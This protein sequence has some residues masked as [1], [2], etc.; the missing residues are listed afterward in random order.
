MRKIYLLLCV[1]AIT[2]LSATTSFSQITVTATA[3]V[4][5]PTVYT[6][7]F[8]AVSAV[9]AGTH[10]G[11][12]NMSVTANTVETSASTLNYSG[13]GLASYTSITIKPAAATSPTIQGTL[14]THILFIKGSNV[15]ID[16]SNTAGGTS[17]DL[18]IRN[19]SAASDAVIRFGSP[20][21]AFGASNNT[22][23]NCVLVNSSTG[24]CGGV[25]LSGS[26]TTAYAIG[27]APNSNNTIQNNS[28][29]G[30]Q[31]GFYSYGPAPALDNGWTIKDNTFNGLG[32]SGITVYNAGNLRISGN[33]I[34]NVS[35]NGGTEVTGICLSWT[36]SGANIYNNNIRGISN[37]YALASPAAMGIYFDLLG[38]ASN[39]NVYNNFVSD[40]IGVGNATFANN[41][42][43]IYV[44]YGGGYNI[45][46]N[47]VNLNTDQSSAAGITAALGFNPAA[48]GAIPAGSVNLK[49]NILMNT[50]TVGA[51]YSIYST[52]PNTIF[53]SIDYNDY[54]STPDL[55]FIGGIR[56]TLANIQAGFGSNLSSI[57]FA[58]TLMSGTDLHLFQS[59]LNAALAVG[60]PITIPL[61][62]TDIDG[63]S[64]SATAPT[65]GADELSGS[66]AY[67]ALANT[68]SATDVT[69]N[70]VTI[71]SSIGV[72]ISGALV[73]RIYFKKGAGTWYSAPGSL[74]SGTATAGTWSFVIS[75]TALGGVTG[76]DVISYYVIAQT[77]SGAIFAKPAMG[78]VASDVNTV[79]TP[80]TTPN[81]YTVQAVSLAGL[82]TTQS[83]CYNGSAASSATFAYTGSAGSPNQYM[84]TWSP[85][86]PTDVAAF[87]ALPVS[88]LTV[89]VPAGTATDIYTGVLTIFNSTTAC[90]NTYTLTLTVNPQPAPIT[91]TAITCVG[92]TTTLS[93]ATSGGGWT[94]TPT[95]TATVGATNGVVM[96]VATGTA[97]VTYT[98]PTGCYI[99]AVFTVS[100]PPAAIAGTGVVCVGATTTLTNSVPGGTWTSANPTYASA[101]TA[102]GVITGGAAGTATISYN[103]SSCPAV[104]TVVTVNPVPAAITGQLGVCQS[105]STTLSDATPGGTWSSSALAVATIGTSGVVHGLTPGTSTITYQLTSTG[106]YRTAMVTVFAVPGPI[107]GADA[108]CIG[109]PSSLFNTATTGTWVSGTPAVATIGLSSGVVT[110][111]MNGTTTI[112]YTLGGSCTVTKVVS[113]STA[114]SV[115]A[116]PSIVCTGKT[117]TL[118][119][120]TAGG[121]WSS[122]PVAIGTVSSTGIVTGVTPGTVTISDSTPGCAMAT[123]VVTVNL[124]PAN[125][126]GITNLCAGSTTTLSNAT[127]GGTWSSSNSAVPVTSSGIVSGVSVGV[128]AVISYTLPNGCFS[129]APIVADT[130]PAPIAGPDSVCKFSS[131]TLTDATPAGLWTSSDGTKAS[132]VAATGVV[133][134]LLSGTVTISYTRVSGCYVTKTFKVREPL[135]ASVT[136]E[137]I[138]NTIVCDGT[139][140]MFIAHPVNGGVDP[141]FRWQ[142]FTIDTAVGDTFTY[143]PHH[144]DFISLYMTPD[145]ICS[146]PDPS[147]SSVYINVYPN[148]V[149]PTVNITTTKV[150]NII[151]F[152]GEIVTF[153]SDITFGGTAPT[154][155][156]YVND[157][158]VPGA[159]NSS[160]TLEVYRSIV[161]YCRVTGN[162]PCSA[163][164]SGLSNTIIIYGLDGINSVTVGSAEFGLF[165]NP[166]TGAFTLNGTITNGT[167]EELAIEVTNMLGQVVYQGKA[168]PHNGAVSQQIVLGSDLAA[169]SYLMRVNSG[170]VNQTFH[171]VISK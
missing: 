123:K 28:L 160:Y 23:K 29:T 146:A 66:I 156:W 145:S 140:M 16:G 71:N 56:T 33:T 143:V 27:E 64:R 7:L 165:P 84:L 128:V 14:A 55:G 167:D 19:N 17:R 57:T 40:V 162:A 15:I 50:E 137:Q 74:V 101:A 135:P 54:Y 18:T 113:V 63:D 98:I 97:T 10:Q 170:S 24:G 144:G 6:T 62:N 122:A 118:T 72:H 126:A 26:G 102:T 152:L 11:I 121:T 138:P 4:P 53:A 115:I 12:I 107:T 31:L 129:L 3:G 168:V 99:T 106:C 120:S 21:A 151:S 25:I 90:V 68:C 158:P 47:T 41:G 154:Y 77:T 114:P 79:T 51:H 103:L 44:D 147:Y 169:G 133:T 9:N 67:T 116:G 109:T 59:S 39:V 136:I 95:S 75:T 69:L 45:H 157:V 8:A 104:T 13:L 46:H 1:V 20:S 38:T 139:P 163:A 127:L 49:D 32:F 130:P 124:N 48:A 150:P 149:V 105:D 92:S 153:Y 34:T 142:K 164:T 81:S 87:A 89:N 100:A 73:P 148:G 171:F 65:I 78:L 125:I 37:T 5:G 134:G 2:L 85:A 43:G 141:T 61:V 119:N 96:G 88:P 80:P 112:T 30:A 110:G 42:H 76:G 35:I 111:A 117:I 52:A 161:V 83:A 36:I 132:I 70:P 93:D 131:V 159:T 60:V 94:I 108:I 22:V 86:G 91:G 82:A 58:P 166:N 155:Q